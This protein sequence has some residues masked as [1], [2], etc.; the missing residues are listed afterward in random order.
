[1]CSTALPGD[2]IFYAD[3]YT[4]VGILA[5]ASC[6]REEGGR[7][8][9]RQADMRVER[10]EECGLRRRE[11]SCCRETVTVEEVVISS[12]DRREYVSEDRLLPPNV[13]RWSIFFRN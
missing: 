4:T 1:M 10:A 13:S 6:S 7:D 5:D 2:R 12:R 8:A 3:T 11:S 9:A